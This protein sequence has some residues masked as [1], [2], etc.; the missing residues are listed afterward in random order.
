MY[1][2]DNNKFKIVIYGKKEYFF[3]VVL[4]FILNGGYM[5]FNYLFL[6]CFVQ[7]K[8]FIMI[9]INGKCVLIYFIENI[10]VSVK[11]KKRFRNYYKKKKR[12]KIFDEVF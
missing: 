2:K 3:F 8:Y 5:E 1:G 7:Q 6:V 11:G 9:E 10:V 4:F 12:V